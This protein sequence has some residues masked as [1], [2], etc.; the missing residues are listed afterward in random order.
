MFAVD[1]VKS[2]NIKGFLR[3]MVVA[4][5]RIKVAG[6]KIDAPFLNQGEEPC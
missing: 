5:A 2:L 6:R 4:V 3:G 1:F